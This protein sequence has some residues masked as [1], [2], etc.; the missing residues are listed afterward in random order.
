[1]PVPFLDLRAQYQSIKP[2]IDAAIQGVID[3]TAFALGPAVAAFEKDFAVYCGT[4]HC[5]GVANGT[6]AIELVL[7]AYGIGAGDEVITA[8]NSFFASSEAI[9]LAGAIPVLVDCH[10]DDALI[11]TEKLEAAITK[12]TKAIIPV[13]LYG[14]CADMDRIKEIAGK[15]GILVI[16]DACQ[17]HGSTYKGKKA[18]SMG[19]AAAFSFYPGKNLGAYGEGGAVTT[20]DDRLASTIRMLRDH[21]MAEKYKHAM[22]GRNER[23]DGIQGAV[24]GV[25]LRYLE[26]WN[27]TRRKHAARYI[28]KLKDVQGITLM[29]RHDRGESNEHLFVVRVRNRDAVQEKMKAA[30]IMTGIHY[31]IPIHLQEAYKGQWKKGGFPVAEKMAPELL[32]LPMYAE[33]TETMIDDVCEA[34]STAVR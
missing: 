16:E 14:Q 32:S 6:V 19:S 34:L 4:K 21:G 28:A 23:L 24:L 27:Q 25:K 13:H 11:D 8:T 3:S 22:V 26:Q 15:H 1:M 12:R 17:A 2:E 5:I 29:T 18:G 10:E 9:S 20:N 33:L 31:P 30:G 7:E